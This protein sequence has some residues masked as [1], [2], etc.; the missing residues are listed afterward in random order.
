[1]AAAWR[2]NDKDY[3][4]SNIRYDENGNLLTMNQKAG[5]YKNLHRRVVQDMDLLT[6]TY[7]PNSNKLVSVEDGGDVIDGLPDFRNGAS[8]NEEYHYDPNGNMT[9]DDNKHLSIAH[10]HLNKPVTISVEGKGII[11][12]T[13]D[14]TGNLL[15][16]VVDS[17][18]VRTIY[19]YFGNFVYKDNVLQ[20][21]LNEEGRTRPIANDT[22]A[23]Y[24][25]FVYDYFIKDHLGNVRST[26]TAEPINSGYFASHEV[27]TASVNNWSLTIYP[28]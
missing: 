14:A 5:K 13:Y 4:V 22:T 20:F 17:S 16:K 26:V 19:D 27:A 8:T 7:E 2:K 15:K 18:G 25:R 28:T 1:M 12:Y 6:Y 9:Q 11:Y 24:T 3:S 23:G 10:N 21:I